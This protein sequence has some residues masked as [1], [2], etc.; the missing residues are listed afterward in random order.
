MKNVRSKI[1][2]YNILINTIIEFLDIIHRP[3]FYLKHN[4][5][6][7]GF[8]LRLIYA[9]LSRLL[10]EDGDRI[11]CPKRCVFSKQRDNG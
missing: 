5:S 6:E 2:D 9:Q 10:P 7:T 3:V 4:V 1:W 8:C 11:Q